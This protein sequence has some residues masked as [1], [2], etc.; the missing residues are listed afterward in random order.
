MNMNNRTNKTYIVFINLP[1][2]ISSSIEGIIKKVSPKSIPK[3][4]PHITIKYDEDL[5]IEEPKMIDMVEEFASNLSPF[6]IRLGELQI[7]ES[8][9]GFNV[10]IQAQPRKKIVNIVHNISKLIEPFINPNSPDAFKST[11]WEQSDKFYPHISIKGA[12]D[13]I[14]AEKIL[15]IASKYYKNNKSEFNVESITLARWNK[16]RWKKVKSFKLQTK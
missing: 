12:S 8:N 6:A 15:N 2:D 11:K 5:L 9:L 10:Y 14:G 3:L 16:N 13:R 1:S 7:N 4:Q